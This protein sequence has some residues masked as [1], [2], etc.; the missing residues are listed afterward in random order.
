MFTLEIVVG[1]IIP[2][3]MFLSK[4]VLKSPPLLFTASSLVI[5]GVFLNRVNNFIVAYTPPYSFGSYFPSIGE[6]SVTVGFVAL[7]VLLYRIIVINFPV[8][9]QPDERYAIKTKYTIRG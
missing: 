2:L 6:I 5:L 7:L 1:I 9:S 8:I 3:R 4:K